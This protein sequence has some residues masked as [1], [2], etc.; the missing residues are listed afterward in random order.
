MITGTTE[1]VENVWSLRVQADPFVAAKITGRLPVGMSLRDASKELGTDEVEF[2]I[3][4]QH[5]PREGWE[6]IK[7]RAGVVVE[8]RGVPGG[9]LAPAVAAISAAWGATAFLGIT[10][11]QIAGLALSFGLQMLA[12]SLFGPKPTKQEKQRDVYSISSARNDLRPFEAVPIV[13]GKHRMTPPLVA[14][15]WAETVWEGSGST[16]FLRFMVTWGYGTVYLED[17][18]IG[19]TPIGNFAG[20]GMQH[21][22]AGS[23]TQMDLYP[24]DSYTEQVGAELA[25]GAYTIRTTQPECREAFIQMALPEGLYR[26]GGSEGEIKSHSF[27]LYAWYRASGTSGDWI[28]WLDHELKNWTTS[29]L[30]NDFRVVFPYA[31]EWD[32]RVTRS[33][34]ED[35]ERYHEVIN[36]SALRSV[37]WVTPV[38]APGISKSA[39]RIRATDQLSG[40][41]DTLNAVVSRWVT[42]W[43]GSA[44]SGSARSS[45]PAALF[46]DVI[47]GAANARATTRTNDENLG[48]WYEYCQL[49]D[50]EYNGIVESQ[51]SVPDLLADIAAAGNAS[52]T[53]FD[54]KWGV[55]IEQPLSVVVQ[56]FTQRNTWDFVG[57][58]SY[59]DQPHALRVQFNNQYADYELDEI[60]V[61]DDGYSAANATKFESFR[62][63]GA[64]RWKHAYIQARH[65]LAAGRLRPETFSFMVDFENLVASRGDLV[66][67]THDVALIGQSAGRI[68]AVAGS[69]LTLDEYVT[70]E[71]GKTYVIRVRLNSGE[72]SQQPV[73]G[74]VGSTKTLTVG[75]PGGILPGDLFVFG[76]TDEASI[77]AIVR[78]I[79][80]ANDLTARV[81]CIPYHWAVYNAWASIPTYESVVS[82]PVSLALRGPATPVILDV[83][84]DES[85]LPRDMTGVPIP[86]ILLRLQPGTSSTSTKVTATTHYKVGWR[87]T[88]SEAYEFMTVSADGGIARISGVDR[89]EAY[90]IIV[91]ALD[92]FGASSAAVTAP[93]HIVTGLAAPPPPVA[94]FR[95]AN[96][97]LNAYV[98]W[99]YPDIPGDVLGYEIRWHP[100]QGIT[101]WSRMTRIATDIPRAARS[102]MVPSNTGSYAIKPF[103]S[104][105]YTAETALYVSS[106]ISDPSQTNVI[107][108]FTEDATWAGSHDGTVVVSG[109]LQ[110]DSQLIVADITDMSAVTDMAGSVLSEGTYTLWSE[111]DLG[112]VYTCRVSWA[113]DITADNRRNYVE[114]WD[115]MATLSDASGGV[116]YGDEYDV[117]MQ[118]SYS[119]DDVASGMTWTAYERFNGGEFTARHFRFKMKLTTTDPLISPSVDWYSISI[120][121]PD[122]VEHGEDVTSGAALYSVDYTS[123]FMASP[124][125][126]INAQ[127]M[128]TGDYYEITNKDETGFDITFKNSAGT[129]V[130]RTF[131]WQAIGIGKEAS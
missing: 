66:R 45:N 110:L 69:V 121:A 62:A 16:Q 115:D 112:A 109:R 60:L 44:W 111:Q 56:H 87:R 7:P 22:N 57:S 34:P 117:E 78:D 104:N 83:V 2:F 3:G 95:V 93:G 123:A 127:D 40:V 124:N 64:T 8:A 105:G 4:G 107:L 14:D 37:T 5:V 32:I 82:S 18:R 20:V 26:I 81:T 119:R 21:D 88:E 128:A 13:L 73:T 27:R 59:P 6:Y 11:G 24:N 96:I 63:S 33:D 97:G 85:A 15:Y 30:Y 29:P 42:T 122:R 131:D 50:L 86:A 36:W 31:G 54:D 126:S 35:D 49:N 72:Y 75:Y 130:S 106:N 48:E 91:Y 108:S 53:M 116:G 51:V 102:Y 113:M 38:S 41:I 129:A 55:V 89:G 94:T 70:F 23:V 65:Y 28:A 39:F 103:D 100:T 71:A 12:S 79:E 125:V 118:I 19:N 61:Y 114:D 46:R 80:P 58:I 120:D 84:S 1:I 67:I 77:Q 98:E 9:F 76:E 25:Y 101:D 68:K 99:T 74:S 43:N 52:P 10:W 47:R 90:D 17:I 92:R